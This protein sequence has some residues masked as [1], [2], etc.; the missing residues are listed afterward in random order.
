MPH[1]A[2][3]IRVERAGDQVRMWIDGE[4][5]PWML[6]TDSIDVKVSPDGHPAVRITILADRVELVDAPF[7]VPGEPS[8]CPTHDISPSPAPITAAP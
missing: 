5:V 7:V 4:E 6:E 2:G 1:V 3:R 8:C